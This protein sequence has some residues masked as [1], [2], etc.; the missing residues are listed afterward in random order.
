MANLIQVKRGAFADLPAL[1]AGEFGFSTDTFQLHVGNGGTNYE[2]LMH[3][4]F[5]A[6]SILAADSDNTPAKL[7]IAEQTLVGR[8]TAGNIVGLTPAQIM[9][10]LSG[11]AAA[12]FAMNT[13][14]ITGVTDPTGAQDA[15][16][17]A[18]VDATVQGLKIH[19]A[20]ACA[21]TEDIALSAEQTLD[22][23][24]TSTDR[25][26]VRAQTAPAE[27][28]IYVSAAG[29]WA[30]ADDL[31]A[32][33]EV[34][35]SFTYVTG[36]TTLGSTGWACTVDPTGF[37]IGTTAMPWAQFSS[38]GYVTASDGLTKTG[39]NIA[40]N[41]NL[42][43][44]HT[45]GEVASDGQV[46]VGTGAGAFA[47]ESGDTLRTSLGL[48]I[49]T[50]VLAEQTVGIAN[51]NLL[52]VDGTPLDTEMAVFTANGLNGLSKTEVMAHLSGGA[53]AAFSMNSQLLSAVLDPVSDQDAATKKWTIDNFGGLGANAA[54]SN[55]ASVALNTA[56]LPDV[57]AADDFGSATLPFKDLW[58]AGGSGT[59]ETNNFQITGTSTSGTRVI[60]FPDS[61]GT[62]LNDVST[63]DGG[64]FA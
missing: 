34:A 58:F 7:T 30:R 16:T 53:T 22:G 48:A 36:G 59:P 13:H 35:G 2:V 32:A 63:I 46:I 44:L 4:L 24:L 12:D 5:D 11:G 56:L 25:V 14:K 45:L 20:V 15:A 1:A 49:G 42:A 3:H 21:T 43:D 9:A 61:T 33:D 37:V 60:T 31:D 40:P 29:A 55:L 39:N 19:D 57:A 18:Y 51:D 26:L 47:Y 17:K 10:L 41:G 27:N 64:A 54:L 52:E 62:V 50:D 8:I 38:A 28:G 6:N 23:I